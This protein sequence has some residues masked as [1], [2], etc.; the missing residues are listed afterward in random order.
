MDKEIRVQ[1]GDFDPG[2]EIEHLQELSTNSGAVVAFIGQMRE[3][4]SE[5]VSCPTPSCMEIEHYP[6]MAEKE[7]DAIV[8]K[9]GNR[10]DLHGV[11]VIHRIGT[12]YPS[13]NIVLVGV[14]SAHRDEAFDSAR[15]IMDFL[16]ARAPFWKKEKDD[17]REEW[18]KSRASDTASVAKWEQK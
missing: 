5:D 13:D 8:T 7:I 3:F 10:W 2:Q 15:F 12:F 4:Q 18:V 11:R 6:G 1:D 9:A 17:E 14:A 16:K